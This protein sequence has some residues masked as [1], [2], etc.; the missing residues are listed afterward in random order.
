MYTELMLVIINCIPY[1]LNPN[2]SP[3]TAA[4]AVNSAIRKQLAA[5]EQ[6]SGTG[7]GMWWKW[8][9]V[10]LGTYQN[11]AWHTVHAC[12]AWFEHPSFWVAVEL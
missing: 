10:V 2:Y 1:M 3:A 5:A 4:I 12:Y 11:S 8:L 6:V 9:L 7:S